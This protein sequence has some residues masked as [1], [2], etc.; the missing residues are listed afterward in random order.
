MMKRNIYCAVCLLTVLCL[1]MVPATAQTRSYDGTITVKPIQL[2]QKGDFLHIDIDFDLKDVKVKSTRGVDFIPQL[3]APERMLNLPKVSIKGRDEYLAYERWL[4][5]M[6]IKEKKNYDKPYAV[7]KG[8]KVKNGVLPYRYMVRY[9]PWMENA[10]LDVQR[11]ECGCGEIKSMNVERLVDKVTLE[12]VLL[13]YVVPPQFAYLQPKAEEI[14]QRDIQAECFLDFEVN[15]INIR[16]EYMNNPQEL[17][18]IR[19][20]IDELKS[21]PNV[22]VNRLDIIGYASP[23][24]TLVTNKR[25]SE[26]R[27]MALRD[28]LASKYDFPRN[29]YYIIFGGENWDGLEKALDTMEIEYK[30]EVLDIIRDIP[31]E[32]GRE[33]KLMQLRG[34]VPYRYMLKYIFPSLRIAICRVNYEVR[35]FNVD[36]AKEE[37]KRRPQNLSLNEMF[38]V[39]NT[40]PVGSQEFID[41]FETAVRMYPKD[42]IANINAATAALSRN[43]LISAER[44]L[45]MVDSM[46]KLPEYSNAMGVLM[47]LK[48][49]YEHAEEYLNVAYES[50]LKVAGY[51]LEELTRKKANASEFRIKNRDK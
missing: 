12:R 31:I 23:E 18:K 40:Y 2:E 41:V 1:D 10:R 17:A 16:P 28:Y 15:R 34:G 20:M 47:L 4:A 14:K 50:G 42:E 22:K 36:E 27:A 6:S 24:G 44:C 29:Q 11:D 33:T 32:K 26:G 13:P 19:K 49:E 48:G 45:N 8:S 51:N 5:V 25:L 30:D 9:E 43:D 39:A 21:D 38:L 37:I 3:V 35:N 46:K 7:E